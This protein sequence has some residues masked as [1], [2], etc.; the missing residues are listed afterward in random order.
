MIEAVNKNR[1]KAR[2]KKKHFEK[3]KKSVGCGIA[4]KAGF[5]VSINAVKEIHKSRII[6]GKLKRPKQKS[7][8]TADKGYAETANMRPTRNCW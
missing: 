7:G 8:W 6:K 4:L 3:P 2:I 1:V 5:K